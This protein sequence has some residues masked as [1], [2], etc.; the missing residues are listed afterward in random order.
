MV[1]GSREKVLIE[2]PP[3]FK[4]MLFSGHWS[5]LSFGKDLEE[6]KRLLMEMPPFFLKCCI[7]DIGVFFHLAETT[8]L[9]VVVSGVYRILP[10]RNG[11]TLLNNKCSK[12]NMDV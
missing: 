11:L 8:N 1:E 9:V 4:N 12:M 10:R 6:G 3:F 7:L 2:M 5:D